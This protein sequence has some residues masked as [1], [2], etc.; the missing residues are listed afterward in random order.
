MPSKYDYPGFAPPKRAVA[1][2]ARFNVIDAA[3]AVAWARREH[4]SRCCTEA[5]AAVC[6]PDAAAALR[7]A[8][9]EQACPAGGW[10][11]AGLEYVASAARLVV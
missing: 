9:D 5:E 4:V 10:L 8:L 6:I 3:R 7:W 2:T 11:D 1:Y